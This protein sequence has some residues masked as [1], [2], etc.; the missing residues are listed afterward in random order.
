[1]IGGLWQSIVGSMAGIGYRL[2]PSETDS[3]HD[4]HYTIYLPSVDR[5]VDSSTFARTHV[6]RDVRVR[7]Q[8]VERKDTFFQR[9]IHAEVERVSTELRS[10][11]L[12]E[13]S[14]L[15]ERSGGMVAEIV[16]S[17]RDSLS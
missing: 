11:L 13:S 2:D 12:F 9:D 5:D 4:R 17:A 16:F 15:I 8:F 14:T 3:L 7:L 1:M 10:V 6:I